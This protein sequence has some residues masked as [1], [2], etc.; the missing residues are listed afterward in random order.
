MKS[1]HFMFA[2]SLCISIGYAHKCYQCYS[3]KSWEHCATK[4]VTCPGEEDHC[5]K[6]KIDK[7]DTQHFSK[8]CSAKSKCKAHESCKSS[9]PPV[10]CK[11]HCCSGDLCNVATVPMVSAIML[12]VCALVAF[13]RE[14]SVW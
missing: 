11:I 12:L 1:I 7:N 4:E 9:D 2:L 10:E 8:G 6:V 5:V 14:V 13:I 3:T